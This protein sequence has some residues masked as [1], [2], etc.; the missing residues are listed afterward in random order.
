MRLDTPPGIHPV[1]HVSLIRRARED[2]L[3]SQILQH[4]E[5]PAIRP[6]EATNELVAG[7]YRVE[8]VTAHRRRGRGWQLLVHWIGWAA[9]TWEPLAHLLETNALG[10]YEETLP[11]APWREGE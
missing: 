1:F 8:K 4:P 10:T 11:N 6:E 3:P 9:P 5:L 2:P 7:E